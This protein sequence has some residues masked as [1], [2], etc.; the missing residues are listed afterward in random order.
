MLQ[1]YYALQCQPN[2]ENPC[3]SCVKWIALTND[4]NSQSWESPQRLLLVFLGGLFFIQLLFVDRLSIAGHP[5]NFPWTGLA[6]LALAIAVLR[7]RQDGVRHEFFFQTSTLFW[8]ILFFFLSDLRWHGSDD[9]PT[10]YLPFSILRFHTLNLDVYARTILDAQPTIVVQGWHHHWVSVYPIL[11]ALLALPVYL[12]PVLRGVPPT[13]HVL[14]QLEKISASLICAWAVCVLFSIYRRRL[15]A[16]TAFGLALIYGLGT[17][18]FSLCS[19]GLWQYGPSSLMLLLSLWFLDRSREEESFAMTGVFAMLAVAA[20]PPNAIFFLALAAAAFA[21]DGLR[22]L[23]RF[24]LGSAFPALL[25]MAYWNGVVGTGLPADAGY[26]HDLF[27]WPPSWE[28]AMGLMISPARGILWFS[29]VVLFGGWGLWRATR[30]AGSP[31]HTFA[32]PLGLGIVTSFCLFSCYLG[33]A[34]GFSF[35]SRYLMEITTILFYFLPEAYE[36]FMKYPMA[37]R[38][39]IGAVAISIFCNAVGAYDGWGWEKIS[40]KTV[41]SLRAYPP[42]YW[43]TSVVR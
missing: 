3:L 28:T 6:L 20:R 35:G 32:G 18:M 17:Q 43:V 14:H 8:L 21:W 29:P 39:W 37:R 16:K 42:I 4:M 26:Q 31:L 36:S 2:A 5:V 1:P 34:G 40:A 24:A 23:F 33:W 9:L 22:A 25:L 11:G 7:W 12:V 41:W 13:D 10:S 38:G 15:D 30:R 27:H 19:Q